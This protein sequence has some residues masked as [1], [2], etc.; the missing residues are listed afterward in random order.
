MEAREGLQ[1]G[2]GTTAFEK[3]VPSRSSRSRTFGIFW[4]DA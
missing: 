2:M 3:T 1:A 4:S